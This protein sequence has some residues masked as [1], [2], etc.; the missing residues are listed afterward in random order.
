MG[1][2]TKKRSREAAK[3]NALYKNRW[4]PNKFP[5][6]H[7]PIPASTPRDAESGEDR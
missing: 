4:T 5:F 3:E 1:K 2:T 7:N 6:G